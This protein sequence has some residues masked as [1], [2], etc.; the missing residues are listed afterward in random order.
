MTHPKTTAT[1]RRCVGLGVLLL[2]HGCAAARAPET[3]MPVEPRIVQTSSRFKKEY[4][5]I[6]GDQLEVSVWRVPELDRKVTLRPDGYI[7]LPLVDEVKASGLTPAELDQELTERYSKRLLNPE[8]T[9]VAEH[10]R[11]PVVYVVGDV[12]QPAAVPLRDAA[13]ALQAVVLAGGL[14]RSAASRDIA[15]IRLNEE[16]YLQAIALTVGLD[17]QPGPYVAL[18]SLPLE[19]DDII[20]VPERGRS[21][22]ARFLDDFVTRPLL[23]VSALTSVV[24]NFRLLEVL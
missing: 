6:P 13:T 17:G 2:T 10:V 5:L 20:F 16:G 7:T 23:G 18:A 3:P 19:A 12:R 14:L 11:Q 15:I 4:V 22:I 21:Q 24:V 8:V 9:V 1:T